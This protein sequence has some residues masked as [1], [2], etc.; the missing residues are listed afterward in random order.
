MN[1]RAKQARMFGHEDLPLFSGT[2]QEVEGFQT[3]KQRPSRQK[4]W[5]KCRLCMDS[6]WVMVD[7]QP[8]QCW[9]Q[10]QEDG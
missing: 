4:S 9:C 3:V 10:G 5:A 1:E 2:T 8:R 7:G 6:G